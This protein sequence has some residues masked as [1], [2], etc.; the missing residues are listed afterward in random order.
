MGV[1]LPLIVRTPRLTPGATVPV[2]D[3]FPLIV[4]VPPSTPGLLTVVALV[5]EPLTFNRPS[6]T[7]VAPV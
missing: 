5:I 7:A 1:K 4:P 6:L 2:P 3:T